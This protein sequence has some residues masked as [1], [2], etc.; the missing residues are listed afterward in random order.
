MQSHEQEQRWIGMRMVEQVFGS[1]D[2]CVGSD[3]FPDPLRQFVVVQRGPSKE[4]VWYAGAE[5][6]DEATGIANDVVAD[7]INDTEAPVYIPVMIVD[8]DTGEYYDLDWESS[9]RPQGSGNLSV[10]FALD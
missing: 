5:D 1:C 7:V 2:R 8:L 9:Y 3:D 4:E 10:D 6:L